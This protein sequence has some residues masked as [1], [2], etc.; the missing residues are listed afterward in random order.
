[1]SSLLWAAWALAFAALEYQGLS[2]PDDAR[3]TLTNRVRRVMAAHPA[4]RIAALRHH[5]GAGVAGP[6]TSSVSTPTLHPGAWIRGL[7]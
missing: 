4:V 5:R 3:Y 6:T 2:D 1:V 7:A